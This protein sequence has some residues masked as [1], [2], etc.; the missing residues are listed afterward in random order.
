MRADASAELGLGHVKRCLALAL[1]LREAGAEV[2]F[3]TRDLG[4]DTRLL[5]RDACIEWHVLGA[6]QAQWQD[7]A[8]DSVAALRT[9]SANWVVVDHYALDARWHTTVASL[10]GTRIAAIDDLGDRDL[11]PALLIDHNYAPDHRAKYARRLDA[12]TPMLAGPR[13]ALLAPAYA[14]APRYALHEEVGSIGIFMGGTDAAGMSAVVLEGCRRHAGFTGPIEIATTSANPHLASLECS[15]RQW[16]GTTTSIDAP[17]LTAFYARH[18]LHIGAGGG[19]SWERCCIGAPTL[20]LV[21][22]PNQEPVIR[23]LSAI[24][25]LST[26]EAGLAPHADS[27]GHAVMALV[28]DPKRRLA[29]AATARRLVDGFG[30]RRV[31]LYLNAAA[32]TVRPA[33]LEDA[34]LMH[35]WRND[36]AT[37]RGS[38]DARVIQWT[39]HVEWLG[40]TLADPSR[41]L[42]IGAVG[43]I[44]VGVI[45]LDRTASDAAEVSLYLDPA[46][47]GLGLGKE[48]LRAGER[49]FIDRNGAPAGGFVA[50][51]LEGNAGSQ[52]LFRSAGYDHDGARWRKPETSAATRNVR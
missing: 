46:L 36:E 31:A 42:L 26:L 28:R 14:A 20:A 40:R 12:A 38:S 22:A 8:L 15:C 33:A 17:N 19:A 39:S 2:S 3:V 10:L 35:R 41:M 1:A 23:E 6:F 51:V 4:V 45:R 52:R 24:G 11:A 47:H 49:H 13:F 18:D 25:A 34:E 27:I 37:R 21:C 48:L 9:W 32:L 29:M 43:S 5:A 30:A 16:P 50:T 7:D 44:P